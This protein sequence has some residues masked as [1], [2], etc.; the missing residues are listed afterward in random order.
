MLLKYSYH[1]IVHKLPRDQNFVRSLQ[2]LKQTTAISSHVS[3]TCSEFHTHV[4]NQSREGVATY[5]R[6]QEK[7]RAPEVQQVPSFFAVL[8][9]ALIIEAPCFTG[10]AR[11][12]SRT[13]DIHQSGRDSVLAESKCW[14]IESSISIYIYIYMYIC[15]YICGI[16]MNTV[17]YLCSVYHCMFILG[18]EN[19]IV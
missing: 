6:I 19:K 1:L 9:S 16:H 14:I 3:H 15:M 13:C 10:C 7:R 11:H 8:F 5:K 17:V 4:Q 2:F 12:A 18:T